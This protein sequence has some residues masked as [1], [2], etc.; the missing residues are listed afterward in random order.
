MRIKEVFAILVL[1]L[2]GCAGVRFAQS[3]VNTDLPESFTKRALYPAGIAAYDFQD[4]V[5]NILKIKQNE[6]PLRIG[7]VRPNTYEAKVIPIDDP[8][9]YYKSR[10]QRGA[11]AKGSYLAFT[12]SFSA[13]QLAEVELIDI[14]RSG[15]SFDNQNIFQEIVDTAKKWV[16][17]HPKTDPTIKRLWVKSAVLTRKLYNE[18]VKIDANASGQTGEVVGVS[19]GIYNKNSTIIKSVILGFEALDID[20][21]VNQSS[22]FTLSKSFGSIESKLNNS[23]F[24]K[25]V[26]TGTIKPESF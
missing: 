1:T 2:T 13:D 7:I 26:I 5:G 17:N 22:S 14:A 12:G 20:E 9:N 16:Q 4:L 10:I 11:S 23:I 24:Y 3:P 19:T 6:D 8:N 18:F 15:I 21:L 25:G